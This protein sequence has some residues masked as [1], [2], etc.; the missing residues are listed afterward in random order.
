[1]RIVARFY[2][3]VDKPDGVRK[4]HTQPVA[5]L[6]GVAVFLGWM[7]GLA[8]S[9]FTS[10]HVPSAPRHVVVNW[11]IFAATAIV[12]L[13]GLRDD[14]HGVSPRIKIGGQ[15]MAGVL[16]LATGVGTHCTASLWMPLHARLLEKFGHSFITDRVVV[17]SSCILTLVL[18]VGCCNA[19]NVMDGM[20]GLCGGVTSIV[21]VGF[22]FVAVNIAASSNWDPNLNALRVVLA[23][24]LLGALLGFVPY[25]FNPASI[26]LGDTGSMLVG[27]CCATLLVLS[28]EQT[29]PKWFLGGMVMFALPVLDAL[30]AIARRLVKKRNVF[31]ADHHHFHHQMLL[32]GF[33][34]KQT[35]AVAYVLTVVFVI[36]GAA[37]A[38]LRTRYVAA[39]YLVVFA[40]IMVAAHKLGMVDEEVR[41]VPRKS[42]ASR[43]SA[44]T[45]PADSASTIEVEATANAGL[46]E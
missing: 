17:V 46:P 25:N 41:S 18:V 37:T 14:M 10:M 38:Y 5:Y 36:G 21:G 11:G 44:A 35:V 4:L 12:A 2:G 6:G 42:L 15:L 13:L 3:I 45:R 24:S 1:M 40:Y 9:Q 29:H 27:F 19:A 28:A 26:F 20:D 32:R 8:M 31:A 30:L 7:A 16:L 22:C 34:I 39:I 33:S 43:S 23:L